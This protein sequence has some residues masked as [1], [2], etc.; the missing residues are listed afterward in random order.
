[1]SKRTLI[2]ISVEGNPNWVDA[3]LRSLR[4]P[5]GKGVTFSPYGTIR[6]LHRIDMEGEEE[7]IQAIIRALTHESV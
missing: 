4:L 6:E 1:M 2:I 3:M 7:L 5:S